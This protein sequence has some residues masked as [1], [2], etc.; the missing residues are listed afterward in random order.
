MFSE[1][2]KGFY[3]GEKNIQIDIYLVEPTLMFIEYINNEKI[4]EIYLLMSPFVKA[5][6]VITQVK[7]KNTTVISYSLWNTLCAIRS[8]SDI[9]K[10]VGFEPKC[11]FSVAVVVVV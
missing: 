8:I 5:N 1:N 2:G 7:T 9:M 6:S 10:Q 3:G 4:Q 11:F